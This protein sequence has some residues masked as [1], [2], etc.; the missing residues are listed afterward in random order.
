V[1]VRENPPPFGSHKRKRKIE[2]NRQT[3]R[4]FVEFASK[5]GEAK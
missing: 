4:A 1:L 3:D 2:R 5:E